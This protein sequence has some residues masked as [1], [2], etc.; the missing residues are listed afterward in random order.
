MRFRLEGSSSSEPS[1]RRAFSTMGKTNASMTLV[2][3]TA[4][5]PVNSNNG[6]MDPLRGVSMAGTASCVGRILTF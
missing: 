4:L 3:A 2:G 1:G 6:H 5:S